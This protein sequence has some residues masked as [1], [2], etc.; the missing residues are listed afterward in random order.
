MFALISSRSGSQS[1]M[2][3]RW[4]LQGHHGPLVWHFGLVM[5]GSLGYSSLQL[6]PVWQFGLIKF[7]AYLH[8]EVW[9]TQ[10]CSL[11]M[12]GSLAYSSLQLTFIWQFRLCKFQIAQD[13]LNQVG[14]WGYSSLQLSFIWL[15][16]LLKKAVHFD[17]EALLFK[18]TACFHFSKH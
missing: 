16:G 18:S 2:L 3:F 5:F 13:W 15:F 17:F 9:V 1:A 4:A 7:A 11:L 10:V 6:T 14:S 8:L 12:F